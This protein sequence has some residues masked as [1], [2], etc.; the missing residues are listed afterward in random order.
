[1]N[2]EN[3]KA[4][5]EKYSYMFTEHKRSKDIMAK[6]NKLRSDY[7]EA[8]RTRNQ[9]Q[10]TEFNNKSRELGSY[11]PIAYGCQCDDGW[12]F[13]LDELCSEIEK[14]DKD[15]TVKVVQVKE[16][17][18]GLRFYTSSDGPVI[19][20]LNNA[21]TFNLVRNEPNKIQALVSKYEEMSYK[22]CEVCGDQGRLC[23][24]NGG[25]LKTVCIE[26][27]SL[28]NWNNIE[29]SYSPVSRFMAD[30]EVIVH[31]NYINLITSRKWNDEEDEW[32][33]TLAN[34][35]NVWEY[36]L[37]HIPFKKLYT[38]WMVQLKEYKDQYFTVADSAFEIGT[39]WIYTIQDHSTYR[40]ISGC[41]EKELTPMYKED[42]LG[43]ISAKDFYNL[44]S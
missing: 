20:V 31:D 17:L 37:K 6:Q 40:T 1:M 15:K 34:G 21:K 7:N 10:M 23:K 43:V 35:E 8:F 4:L 30:E 11:D 26:H 24:T 19:D 28:I 16:K 9:E 18:G 29:Q 14:I 36:D 27:R 32:I 13:L 33:Y 38:D 25:Y 44:K 12:Y 2:K 3:T 39:G 42:G 41:K 22:I 5:F